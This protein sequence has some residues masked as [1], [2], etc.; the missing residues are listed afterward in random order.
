[1]KSAELTGISDYKHRHFTFA[2]TYNRFAYYYNACSHMM[3]Q[4]YP[5]GIISVH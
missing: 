1:M 3:H 5:E 4:I 2:I